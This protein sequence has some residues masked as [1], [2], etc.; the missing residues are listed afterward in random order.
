MPIAN[1]KKHCQMSCFHCH[2]FCQDPIILSHW[3]KRIPHHWE[4][5]LWI[6]FPCQSTARKR[7]CEDAMDHDQDLPRNCWFVNDCCVVLFPIICL[8]PCLCLIILHLLHHLPVRAMLMLNE[9]WF[10]QP[11]HLVKLGLENQIDWSRYSGSVLIAET[12]GNMS[13]LKPCENKGCGWQPAR[14]AG[15]L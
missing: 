13:I 9:K 12:E 14:Q 10:T 5:W 8:G 15:L 11:S 4:W 7:R 6:K 3:I 2:C 1:F